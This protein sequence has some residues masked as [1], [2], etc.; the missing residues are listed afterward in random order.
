MDLGLEGKRA[1]ITGAGRGL[2]ATIAEHLVQEGVEVCLLSRTESELAQV[3]QRIQQAGGKAS[4]LS[5]I[6]QTTRLKH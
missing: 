5:L 4:L 1:L 2:G 3:V 6:W